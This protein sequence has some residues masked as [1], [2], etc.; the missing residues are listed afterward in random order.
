MPH[1]QT[2]PNSF[3]RL[4]DSESSP[5]FDDSSDYGSDDCSQATE[6]NDTG[7]RNEYMDDEAEEGD[8]DEDDQEQESED[9][10][11]I[12]EEEGVDAEAEQGDD[13]EDDQEQENED[14]D[15]AEGEEEY[16]FS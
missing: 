9:E 7:A 1:V 15:E 6:S 13:K 2:I 12:D 10:E 11:E 3:E 14:E 5:S 4:F 8:E 16:M